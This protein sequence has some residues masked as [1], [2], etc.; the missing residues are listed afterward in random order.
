MFF[1]SRMLAFFTTA[2]YV[3]FPRQHF[4]LMC[5]KMEVIVSTRESYMLLFLPGSRS[6]SYA[7][8]INELKFN[9]ASSPVRQIKLPLTGCIPLRRFQTRLILN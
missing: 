9:E 4:G 8:L 1:F 6:A 2:F 7:H 5:R 3:I